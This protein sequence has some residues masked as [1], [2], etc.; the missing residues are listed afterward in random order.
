MTKERGSSGE[1]VESVTLS[2]VLEVFDTTRGPV[3]LSAD[4]AAAENCSRETARRKL[5]QLYERG[6]LARRKVSNRVLY[7]RPADETPS[8]TDSAKD[9][10]TESSM[11]TIEDGLN[12]D[13]VRQDVVSDE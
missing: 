3:V 13:A 4:V 6:D 10:D 2:D 5:N 11:P 12:P 7:W 9:T 1:Y 8:P